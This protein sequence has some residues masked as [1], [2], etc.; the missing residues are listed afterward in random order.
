MVE[1]IGRILTNYFKFI[2]FWP[3]GH[4]SIQY[5]LYTTSML[6]IFFIFYT[7]FKCLYL[8]LLKSVS[9]ATYLS[10][11]CL[12]EITLIVKIL[13]LLYINDI[14]RLN[15][16]FLERFVATTPNEERICDRNMQLFRKISISYLV[17]TNATSVLSFLVPLTAHTP[18]LPFLAW[19]PVDWQHQRPIYW[20]V[21]LYQV[22][23]MIIQCNT[24]VC[25]EMYVVYLMIVV[26]TYLKVL[27]HRLAHIGVVRNEAVDREV[28]Q[29]ND[30]EILVAAIRCHK[31][32]HWY[33]FRPQMSSSELIGFGD[34]FSRI[35]LCC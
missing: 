17:L 5:K 30:R 26:S 6:L 32:I 2:G 28:A 4:R 18:T 27:A 14:V 11:V 3:S 31:Y 33:D 24:L 19:Y 25:I 15:Q 29:S 35:Q 8:P 9:E 1:R 7:T 23:G 21:Y 13:W 22:I 34:L 12:T 20:A 16:K 10:F